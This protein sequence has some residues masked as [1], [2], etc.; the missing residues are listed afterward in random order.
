MTKTQAMSNKDTYETRDVVKHYCSLDQLQKPE[1]TIFNSIRAELE[2]MKMLDIGVGVGRTTAYFA[3]L[4]N[5][6]IGIDYSKNMIAACEKRFSALISKDISFKICDVRNMKIFKDN[7]FDFI[8]FSFNGLDSMSHKDRLIALQEIIRVGKNGGLFCFSTHNLLYSPELFTIHFCIN[9]VKM[10]WRLFK[11]FL[12]RLLNDD[13]K[14][15]INKNYAILR[16]RVHMFRLRTYYIK[17]IE[18]IKQLSD[19]GLKNIKI[20][21]YDNGNE[22]KD[23]SKLDTIKCPHLYYICVIMKNP[24][25]PNVVEQS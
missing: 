8:L 18:Q 3:N 6:Y 13:S 17:P 24:V 10:S 19:L 4:V 22:I 15:L 16:T 25:R 21:S 7:Y 5:E 2:H 9:P 11:Y 20:Y 23:L 14:K 12:I 1:Q